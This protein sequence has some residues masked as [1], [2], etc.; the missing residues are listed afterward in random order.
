MMI[1]VVNCFYKS[2]KMPQTYILLTAELWMVSTM[3]SNAWLV[4]ISLQIQVK[5]MKNFWSFQKVFK[6]IVYSPWLK[7]WLKIQDTY[8][9]C[10]C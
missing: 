5:L 3:L 9:N 2:I 6:L 1:Y 10:I 4:G 8:Q 7:W